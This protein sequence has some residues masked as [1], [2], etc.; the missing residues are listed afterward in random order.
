MIIYGTTT[1]LKLGR[2]FNELPLVAI[3][4]IIY[5]RTDCGL[6]VSHCIFSFL[7]DVLEIL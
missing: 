2:I 6:S 7:F 4:W 1:I 5:K 3:L